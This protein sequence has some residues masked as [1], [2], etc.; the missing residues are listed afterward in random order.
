MS[1]ILALVLSAS[2][3]WTGFCQGAEAV[4]RVA[5]VEVQGSE[6]IRR[7]ALQMGL[8]R[9]LGQPLTDQAIHRSVE[10]LKRIGRAAGVK[11]D[12]QQTPAGTWVTYRVRE[13]PAVES[14]EVL[15][16]SV[17]SDTELRQDFAVKPGEVLDWDRLYREVNRIPEI[18]LARKGVL[19]AGVLS[20]LAVQANGGKVTIYVQE[21]RLK[22]LEVQ[23]VRGHLKDAV[24]ASLSLRRGQVLRRQ[25]LLGGLFNAY[26][27]PGIQDIEYNPKFDREHGEFTLVLNLTEAGQPAVSPAGR[28]KLN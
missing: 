11:G 15:G 26:Q 10:K 7:A 20:P 24:L 5:G 2:L 8:E 21:F 1:R 18:Y 19:Y 6:A 9:E 14:I 25:D 4:A 27:L 17:I 28:G 22:R 13:N 16:N 23:G 3:V 12:F